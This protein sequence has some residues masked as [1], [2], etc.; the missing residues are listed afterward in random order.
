[1]DSIWAL[2]HY[3]CK[4]AGGNIHMT[5]AYLVFEKLAFHCCVTGNQQV[6]GFFL[7]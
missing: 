2:V 1:M 7:M 5:V 6:S 4:A 3:F